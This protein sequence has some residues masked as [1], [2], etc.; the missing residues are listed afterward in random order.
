MDKAVVTPAFSTI[1]SVHVGSTDAL[2]QAKNSLMIA[3]GQPG[4]PML[5]GLLVGTQLQG[6]EFELYGVPG[7]ACRG[8]CFVPTVYYGCAARINPRLC[9]H[10]LGR[11][12]IHVVLTG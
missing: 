2:F 5:E 7:T 11:L 10:F 3:L 8:E 12:S 4:Q 9:S 1:M 6:L